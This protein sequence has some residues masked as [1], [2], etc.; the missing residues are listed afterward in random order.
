MA[1]RIPFQ[2]VI[3]PNEKE[4]AESL[5]KDHSMVLYVNETQRPEELE[6]L[7]VP[8]GFTLL[9]RENL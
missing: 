9:R 6:K 1:E 8:Q 2:H 3:A 7:L 5:F 4:W